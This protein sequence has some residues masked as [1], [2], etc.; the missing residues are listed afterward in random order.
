MKYLIITL[1]LTLLIFTC[2]NSSEEKE[3]LNNLND[4]VKKLSGGVDINQNDIEGLQTSVNDNRIN[5]ENINKKI[6]EMEYKPLPYRENKKATRKPIVKKK[7]IRKKKTIKVDKKKVDDSILK[8]EG[9]VGGESFIGSIDSIPNAD[10]EVLK[11]YEEQNELYE[12]WKTHGGWEP[13][14]Y[15]QMEDIIKYGF[16]P[17]TK[18]KLKKVKKEFSVIPVSKKEKKD[19]LYV[20][21]DE[22]A[23]KKVIEVLKDDIMK[24][25]NEITKALQDRKEI[26]E[27]E[28]KALQDEI[29]R[30]KAKK[31]ELKKEV[32]QESFEIAKLENEQLNNALKNMNQ[33]LINLEL[34]LTN[35]KEQNKELKKQN[36]EYKAKIDDLEDDEDEDDEEEGDDDE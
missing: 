35:L 19:E 9:E 11:K 3:Q 14:P 26:S 36:K 12:L 34:E 15:Q 33:L 7:R 1:F 20:T 32:D 27:K 21:I 10:V 23:F 5:I 4:T 13:E 30:L 31:E 18:D 28:V 22:K 17:I 29:E 2:N 6:E 8:I 16:P 25:D 24:A